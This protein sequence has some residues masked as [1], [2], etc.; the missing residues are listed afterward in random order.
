MGVLESLVG[1]VVVGDVGS[2]TDYEGELFEGLQ[3]V[4]GHLGEVLR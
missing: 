1:H 3:F 4:A 2:V